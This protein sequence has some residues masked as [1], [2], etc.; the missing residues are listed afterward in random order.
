MGTKN[1]GGLD[2]SKAPS[3]VQKN[4]AFN[5]NLNNIVARHTGGAV[6]N[7][8]EKEP[9]FIDNSERPDF[10]TMQTIV[11]EGEQRFMRLP[12]KIRSIFQNQ[13]HKMVEFVN[14]PNNEKR[15]IELGL[16]PATIVDEPTPAEVVENKDKPSKKEKNEES[17]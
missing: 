9:L 4:Q 7:L 1:K 5:T 11:V 13:A 2:F 15:S 8:I 14:N 12:A 6:P 16:I 3:L 10:H 17:E